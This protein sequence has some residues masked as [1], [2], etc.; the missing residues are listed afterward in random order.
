MSAP[1]T[2]LSLWL[3]VLA[4]IGPEDKGRV[5][6]PG[7]VKALNKTLRFGRQSIQGM[8]DNQVYLYLVVSL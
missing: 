7:A 2:A 1:V 3:R 5:F 8:N 4:E 6:H